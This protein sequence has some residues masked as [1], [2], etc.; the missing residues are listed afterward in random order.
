MSFFIFVIPF[1]LLVIIIKQSFNRYAS[2]LRER[3]GYILWFAT[4]II[5]FKGWSNESYCL[6][7]NDLVSN[8]QSGYLSDRD[9][10]KRRQSRPK[11]LRAVPHRQL[12]QQAPDEI[13][14][15]M[16]KYMESISIPKY[17]G[18]TLNKDLLLRGPSI[19][20]YTGAYGIFL[21]NVDQKLA[22]R[23]E[24]GHIHSN[25]GSF[26]MTVHPADAKLLIEKQWAER[27]PLHGINLF[28]KIVLSDTFILIYAPQDEEE[29]SIWKKTLHAAI[30]Y[31]RKILET[32]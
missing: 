17:G 10:P 13:M 4:Q 31:N 9:I 29:L 14:H 19:L 22:C 21:P 12:T 20:E 11:M 1:I 5:R 6:S 24:V 28:N 8:D 2:G 25:D 26:H 16:H 3:P 15:E 32:H 18:Q 23:S 30:D 27:F 7:T